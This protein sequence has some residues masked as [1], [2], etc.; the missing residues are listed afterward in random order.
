METEKK[1]LFVAPAFRGVASRIGS[2]IASRISELNSVSVLTF[3]SSERGYDIK[4]GEQFHYES[5]NEGNLSILGKLRLSYQRAHYIQQLVKKH[6]INVII[7]FL[8]ESDVPAILSKLWNYEAKVIASVRGNPK[9]R[10]AGL[11]GR[12]SAFVYKFADIVVA[13]SKVSEYICRTKYGLENTITIYNPVNFQEIKEKLQE[14]LSREYGNIFQSGKTFINVGRLVPAKGQWHLIRAF[15]KVVKEHPEAKLAILGE[16]VL[17]KELEN[18][19]KKCGLEE[20]VFLLGRQEN[21]FPFLKAADYFVFSSLN[22]GLPNALLEAKT[23]GLPIISTDCE[24]GPREILAPELSVN[25]DISYPYNVDTGTMVMPLSG[26][27]IFEN[28]NDHSLE[29]TEKLLAKSMSEQ[30]EKAVGKKTFNIDGRFNPDD[31]INKW[32]KII[33]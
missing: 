30:A 16:G 24:T 28:T 13:N 18:L 32:R 17:R 29:P 19:I 14:P 22:E 4:N 27:K 20:N 5:K 1:I 15:K 23:V 7:S 26:N 31:I 6:R 21:V 10:F 9:V 12:M 3:K 33:S 11:E 8:K 2:L 25:E